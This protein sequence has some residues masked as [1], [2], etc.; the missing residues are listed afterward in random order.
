MNVQEVWYVP[1]ATHVPHMYRSHNKFL[2]IRSLFTFS[3]AQD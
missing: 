1:A 3:Y 2:S